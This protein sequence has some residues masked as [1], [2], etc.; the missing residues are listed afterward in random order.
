MKRVNLVSSILSACLLLPDA[1]S[2]AQDFLEPET[3]VLSD[4]ASIVDDYVIIKKYLL[5]GDDDHHEARMVCL[6]SF[7]PEWAV[8]L[9][10][11]GP[12][13]W[14]VDLERNPV[15]VRL[16]GGNPVSDNMVHPERAYFFQV[17][18]QQSATSRI[19]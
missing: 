7:E 15:S 8:T 3:G 2:A 9:R 5:R 10:Q 11:T 18:P 14:V 6:P 13:Q 17:T 1:E 4:F 16:L 12:E 19:F